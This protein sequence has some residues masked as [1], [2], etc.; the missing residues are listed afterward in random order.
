M[1]AAVSCPA[2]L[3]IGSRNIVRGTIKGVVFSAGRQTF[4]PVTTV[5]ANS[6]VFSAG[7]N[8]K[9]QYML[10]TVIGLLC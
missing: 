9:Q 8:R 3:C 4:N 6:A 7:E 10:S 5:E 1:E 2:F